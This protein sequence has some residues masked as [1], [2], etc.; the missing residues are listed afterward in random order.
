[1]VGGIVVYEDRLFRNSVVHEPEI[2]DM[3][4]RDE[5]SLHMA[6]WLKYRGGVSLR[7]NLC[8]SSLLCWNE[9]SLLNDWR[10]GANG[11]LNHIRGKVDSLRS[12]V[13]FLEYIFN[14]IPA[15]RLA[16]HS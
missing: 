8:P 12:M 16:N 11:M 4:V 5:V 6:G 1:M 15:P 3:L 10:Q 2:R 14:G 9:I 13:F 7:T